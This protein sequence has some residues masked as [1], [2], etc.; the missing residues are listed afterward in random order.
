M[1]TRDPDQFL[2][3]LPA[4]DVGK[5]V[6]AMPKGIF[7]VEPSGFR[8]SEQTA[9]DNTYMDTSL[10]VSPTL[11]LDQHRMLAERIGMLGV[12]V[13][14]FPGQTTTPDDLFV[15]NVFAT[16]SGQLIIGSMR[17]PQRRL[18]AKRQDIVQ[19]F[20]SIIG[21]D[22]QDLSVLDGVSE[23]TGVLIIDRARRCGFC[24]LSS[25]VDQPGLE[26]MHHAF[27]LDLTLAFE[28]KP[29]EYHTNVVMS[30]L[31]NRC[32]VL[33]PDALVD[34]V[35]ANVISKAF[36]D[37][38]ITISEAEKAAFVA[39]CLAITPEDVM[40]S[41]TSFDQ[42]TESTKKSFERH[43]FTLH[44]VALAEIEK[45]GGSVRCCLGEIY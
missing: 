14:R 39:N 16:T 44:P 38:I 6:Q 9:L 41:E 25:R 33:C 3:H 35:M 12:P 30:I 40:M 27:G 28:L 23:L 37:Q 22:I 31:A 42:M 10:A 29:S 36:N 1:I 20:R 34:P 7:M 15:N 26:A 24:G 17:H 11:A 32:V 4:L 43:G 2:K 19:F 5:A 18:E 45:A 21:Y 13:I 8:I